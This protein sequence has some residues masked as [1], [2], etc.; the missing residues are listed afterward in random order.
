MR[1]Q[2][3]MGIVNSH[4]LNSVAVIRNKG[5]ASVKRRDKLLGGLECDLI[6]NAFL[7]VRVW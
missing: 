4:F 5:S 1:D 7:R 6:R 2:I 3:L